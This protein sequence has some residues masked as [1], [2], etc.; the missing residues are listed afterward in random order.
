VEIQGTAE[1]EPFSRARFDELI[2]LAG[3][4]IGELVATQRAVL[5]L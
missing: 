3:K 1:Q 5:G 4:G 2:E